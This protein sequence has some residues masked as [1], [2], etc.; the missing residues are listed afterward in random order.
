MSFPRPAALFD[1][2]HEWQ[3]LSAFTTE[4][5]PGLRIGVVRG[6]RR[7]GKSFLLEHLCEAVGGVY[8]LALRQSRTM[9]LAR[10]ADSL[11]QALGHGLGTFSGWVEALDTAVE[12]L[13]RRAGDQ[14]PLLV[15]D[16]FPYLVAHS[17]ELPSV[18]QALYDRRG[19]RKGHPPF[20]LIL[21]GSAISVMSTL[22]AGDQALRGRAVLDMRVGPFGF[23]D[24][25][26]YWEAAPEIAFL[27]DAVLGGAPGYRDV[28]GDAPSGD[29]DG[30]FRWLER[31]M[32]N[33]SHIL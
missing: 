17:P 25:A 3:D 28:V 21:C 33:P 6:R 5:T 15:L 18:I 12:A 20:K 26:D 29:P 22:L 8:T 11:S 7:H 24:A 27:V 14:P 32:L 10:F 9:A 4:R 16:E 31:T 2:V 23:R 1:R 19:P 13:S 30:F